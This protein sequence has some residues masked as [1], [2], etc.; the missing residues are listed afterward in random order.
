M[1]YRYISDTS[2]LRL[3]FLPSR[4]IVGSENN[5]SWKY[6]MR[7]GTADV[8]AGPE[9]EDNEDL[10]GAEDGRK[11]KNQ[12]LFASTVSIRLGNK[13]RKKRQHKGV[14]VQKID[15][16]DHLNDS[17]CPSPVPSS[18]QDSSSDVNASGSSQNSGSYQAAQGSIRS[19]E[20]L[21]NYTDEQPFEDK[22]GD[23]RDEDNV[24]IE[25]ISSCK[26]SL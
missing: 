12:C 17:S 13:A 24:M 15:E 25:Q 14:I 23:D 21:L 6:T 8:K 3:Q 10:P 5:M 1:G 7:C 11:F 26:V 20:A 18:S 9:A 2:D 19:L 4:D 22:D 16:G